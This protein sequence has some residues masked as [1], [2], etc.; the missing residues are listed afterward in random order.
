MV[1]TWLKYICDNC[2]KENWLN[3]DIEKLK[4]DR[5]IIFCCNCGYVRGPADRSEPADEKSSWLKCIPYAGFERK[6]TR[7]PIGPSETMTAE[8]HWGTADG[9]GPAQSLSRA[10]YM[11]KYGI[12][13]WT[14]WCSRN[15]DKKIC[16]DN[17]QG[18]SFKDRC[19]SSQK[20]ME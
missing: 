8:T 10:E 2:S 1:T 3:G 18:R 19:K 13:P 17:G 4:K 12:D 16:Q 6:R 5:T 15:P 7:G 14:D 9:S 20:P 11:V